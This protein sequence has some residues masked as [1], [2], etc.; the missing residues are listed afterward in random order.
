[1]T[2]THAQRRARRAEMAQL[3]GDGL[4][5]T[6]AAKQFGV[7]ERTV[8]DACL[9]HGIRSLRGPSPRGRTLLILAEL[10]NTS[11]PFDFVARKHGVARATVKAIFPRAVDAGIRFPLRDRARRGA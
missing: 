1:M 8:R 5:L 6:D 11:A 7:C 9:Q 4:S 2:L 3:V 10:L